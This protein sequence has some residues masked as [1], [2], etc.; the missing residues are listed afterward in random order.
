MKKE[1]YFKSLGGRHHYNNFSVSSK[2]IEIYDPEIFQMINQTIKNDVYRKML[3]EGNLIVNYRFKSN[4]GKFLTIYVNIGKTIDI[5]ENLD[6]I[7]KLTITETDLFDNTKNRL[8]K[9]IQMINQ[10]KS[11]KKRE[12]KYKLELE[13]DETIKF[14]DQKG[15]INFED[16]D[17]VYEDI[18]LLEEVL[19]E[20]YGIAIEVK[21]GYIINISKFPTLEWR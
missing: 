17:E 13:N 15:R 5:A 21:N 9:Y 14:L 8:E 1:K 20:E 11:Y 19:L 3:D 18:D 10:K 6:Y 7:I 16:L 12:I 4:T 2:W